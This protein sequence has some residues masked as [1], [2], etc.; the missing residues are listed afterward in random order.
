MEGGTAGQRGRGGPRRSAHR[1]RLPGQLQVHVEDS[2]QR[3]AYPRVRLPTGRRA[4]PARTRTG[5]RLV[6]RGGS[7]CSTNI[8]T[9]WSAGPY[10]TTTRAGAPLRPSGG[11]PEPGTE[12]L[13]GFEGTTPG[14]PP[15]ARSLVTRRPVGDSRSAR[16]PDLD[17]P[18]S[19]GRTAAIRM[20]RAAG[21]P[22]RALS[23]E[24]ARASVSRWHTAL[25]AGT[26]AG[27]AVLWRLLR[28]GSAPYFVL[29]SSV[30]RSLRLRIAT[31]WDWKQLFRLTRFEVFPQEGGQPRVGWLATVR[32]RASGQLHEV[33]GHVEVRWSHGRFG[34]L[35][36]A[37]GYLDTHHHLVPGYFPLQ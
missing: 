26:S 37:K 6:R 25:A 2:L 14:G 32:G 36:E 10:E 20:A 4:G 30:S 7:R 31:P 18:G 21:A 12:S 23:D 9:S 16:R 27:E 19:S 5:G 17:P 28:M 15:S 29:G 24:V 3:L 8:C 22:Y 34:G 1:P 33:A 35:P 11:T 13:P